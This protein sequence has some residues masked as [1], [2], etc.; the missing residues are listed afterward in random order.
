[1]PRGGSVRGAFALPTGQA[2]H[3]VTGS[4]FQDPREGPPRASTAPGTS[5]G[6]GKARVEGGEPRPVRLRQPE[7][8]GIGGARRAL[9]PAGNIR[10]PD[11]VAYG[12][13]PPN[14]PAGIG[15]LVR[16]GAI[17]V[18]IS[19]QKGYAVPSRE[20]DKSRRPRCALSSEARRE[21]W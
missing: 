11:V 6:A 17:P 2:G 9:T 4:D 15:R 12:L 1:M 14:G 8:V 20:Q 10:S 7:E 3:R 19:P 13:E 16:H 5:K 21:P 18:V